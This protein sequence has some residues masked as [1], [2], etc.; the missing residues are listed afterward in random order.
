M[1]NRF[2][3]YVITGVSYITSKEGTSIVLCT[4]DP[5]GKRVIFTRPYTPYF[6]YLQSQ[7]RL[8]K[9]LLKRYKSLRGLIIKEERYFYS[10]TGRQLVKVYVKYPWDVKAFSKK[11]ESFNKIFNKKIHLYEANVLFSYRYLIDHEIYTTIDKDIR[12][13]PYQEVLSM[14]I[15]SFFNSYARHRLMFLDIEV[16]GDEEWIE[17]SY[18][19]PLI[20]IGLFD[21]YTNKYYQLYIGSGHKYKGEVPVVLKE[22]NNEKDLLLGF[23]ELYSSISP[24]VIVTFSPFDVKYLYNRLK[25]NKID[26]GFLS[27]IK[28][29]SPGPYIHCVDILDFAELY[30]RVFEEPLWNT[31][32]YISK[33]ELGYGKIELPG[34]IHEVWKQ[35]PILI[36]QYNL[37]DVKL[38]KDLEDKLKLIEGYIIP[39]WKITGLKFSD[40]LTPYK[41]GDILYLRRGYKNK[42]VWRSRSWIRGTTYKGALVIAKPGIY[43]Y[44][45][46]LDWSELYPSLMETF[47]ISWDTIG[48][49]G[50]PKHVKIEGGLYFSLEQPGETILLMKPLREERKKI[51]EKL[52]D[53]SLSK[54]ERNKYKMLSSAYKSIVNSL[55][56]LYG[57]SGGKKGFGSR[58]YEPAIASAITSM[59]RLIFK[60]TL[61]YCS[62]I[63]RKIVYGDTDSIFI[64][65]T[66]DNYEEE[67]K[68]LAY[69]ITS[70]I[71]DFIQDNYK[72]RSTLK[73]TLE[74]IF[75][76]VIILTKKR[77]AGITL[78]GEEIIKGLEI[79]RRNTSPITI[80]AQKKILEILLKG[81]SIQ[82]AIKYRDQIYRE[83]SS[84]K[85]SLLDIALRPRCSKEKYDTLTSNYKARIIGEYYL[86][87]KISPKKRF[88]K[89]Y[90]LETHK[91][92]SEVEIKGQKIIKNIPVNVIAL[93]RIEDFPN[94]LQVDY[95]K[96]AEVTIKKPID[97]LLDPLIDR[98]EDQKVFKYKDLTSFM[99]NNDGNRVS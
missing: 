36:L 74:H 45:A 14:N 5:Q 81:G 20:I 41:I 46:V 50:G 97:N 29:I 17:G 4:R 48:F 68:E 61:N 94:N 34:P 22:Y 78:E 23:K 47:H 85:R 87:K 12:P 93:P 89:L 13:V 82:D 55:Y 76:R 67:A 96:M 66:S 52:K 58:V 63:G 71:A 91:I 24:D 11:V 92:K 3:N 77:Y 7:E 57:F 75:K 6:Y 65:L 69:K 8:F 9:E 73:L 32:D 95:K 40:C 37:R 62:K 28:K 16:E 26:P 19:Y 83:V 38:L 43:E 84:G 18:K 88:Y 53:P 72:V 27:P 25:K 59:G 10:T 42:K 2:I 90:L 79:V 30:R 15:P 44:V 60:E 64:I 80:E 54:E 39:I 86:N 33:K 31:L 51:K 99:V 35:D 70:H 21:S 49:T 1:E 56:G 98:K